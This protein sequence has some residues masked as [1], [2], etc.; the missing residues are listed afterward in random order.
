[1]SSTYAKGTTVPANRSRDEIERTLTRFGARSFA[2]ATEGRR[3]MI[4]FKRDDRLVR[5]VLDL[6]DPYDREFTHT[7]TGQRRSVKTTETAYD[8]AVRE[9]WRALALVV[10]AMLTAVDAGIL[11]FEDAFLS[12]FVLPGGKTVGEH[13][14]PAIEQ[15]YETGEVRLALE[16]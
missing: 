2:Y 15:A 7:P 14:A 8:Q 16:P 12:Y 9:R 5:M 3:A 13:M 1:M 6:P 11:T 4:G 10:K